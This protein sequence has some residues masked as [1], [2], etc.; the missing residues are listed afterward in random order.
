[1]IKPK[2]RQLDALASTAL[3]APYGVAPSCGHQPVASSRLVW[4]ADSGTGGRIQ[5]PF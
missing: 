3:A 2:N 1:V 4:Q 5:L